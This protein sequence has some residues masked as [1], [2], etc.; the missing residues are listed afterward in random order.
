M[1]YPSFQKS[2]TNDSEGFYGESC[3]RIR[4]G[5]TRAR[6]FRSRHGCRSRRAHGQ[7]PERGRLYHKKLLAVASPRRTREPRAGNQPGGRSGAVDRAY[8]RRYRNPSA[9]APPPAEDDRSRDSSDKGPCRAFS[10]GRINRHN[11]R[12]ASAKRRLSIGRRFVFAFVRLRFLLLL[13]QK[14][15]KGEPL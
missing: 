2:T 11:E 9:R 10:S 6:S 5:H 8:K 14:P 13:K 1:Y 12:F 3:T 4:T 15:G 7:Q